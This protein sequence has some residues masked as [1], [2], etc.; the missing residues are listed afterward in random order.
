MSSSGAIRLA[1]Q[2]KINMIDWKT[3]TGDFF[4][5]GWAIGLGGILISSKILVENRKWSVISMNNLII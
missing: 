1:K 5:N 4:I 2:F 3:L